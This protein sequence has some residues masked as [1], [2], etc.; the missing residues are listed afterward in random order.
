[1][2]NQNKVFMYKGRCFTALEDQVSVVSAKH[3]KPIV[4]K[5]ADYPD[6]FPVTKE[7]IAKLDM[8]LA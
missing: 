4:F 7:V 6:F 5:K 1:M 8:L 2:S 3:P